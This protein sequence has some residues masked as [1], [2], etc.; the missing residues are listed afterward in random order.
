MRNDVIVIIE[1]CVIKR[2]WICAFD[3]EKLIVENIKNFL[4]LI[5]KDIQY[6]Y[7]YSENLIIVDKYS[8]T[9]INPF[10]HSTNSY[11]YNGITLQL[12]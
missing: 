7:L 9:L 4:E 3:C 8:N 2:E 12:Y 6:E 10:V 11:L 5:Y 1:I